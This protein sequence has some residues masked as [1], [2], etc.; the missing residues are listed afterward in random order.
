M[1][2]MTRKLVSTGLLSLSRGDV[3]PYTNF[4]SYWC[5]SFNKPI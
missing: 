1:I 5:C 2:G 4:I 3:L